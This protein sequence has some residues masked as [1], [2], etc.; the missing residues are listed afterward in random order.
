MPHTLA[1]IVSRLERLARGEMRTSVELLHKGPLARRGEQ[2]VRQSIQQ[3]LRKRSGGLLNSV[4]VRVEPD[5]GGTLIRV[6]VDAP[7]ARLLDQGGTVVPTRA[8]ALAIPIGPAL[9]ADGS[10]RYRS[11]RQVPRDLVVAKPKGK[12]AILLDPKTGAVWYILVPRISVRGRRYLEP[13][14][15]QLTAEAVPLIERQVAAL[16]EGRAR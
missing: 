4:K 16:I 2:L 7:Q 14:L 10:P 13:A 3:R 9:R 12:S 11:P 8:K 6:L 15:A 1:P 5:H